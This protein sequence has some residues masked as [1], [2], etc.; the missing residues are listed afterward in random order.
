MN[1][2]INAYA[3]RPNAG[4]EAGVAWRLITGLAAFHEL[5]VITEGEWRDEIERELSLVPNGE[6]IHFYFNPVSE[7]IRRMC[8]NQ[9]DYRFYFYYAKWQKQTLSI[10]KT[11]VKTTHIDIIHQLNMIGFREPGYLYEIKDIPFVWGP[12]GGMNQVPMQYLKEAP[13]VTRLKYYLKNYVSRWQYT[14]YN[15]VQRVMD[16]ADALIAA[17]KASYEV[18]KSQRPDKYVE[19]I[20]E[21]GCNN[22][23]PDFSSKKYD[24]QSFRILWVGRFIPTKLLDLSLEVINRIK[25]LD[26]VEFHIVGKAF[27]EKDTEKY[28]LKASQMGLD[29]I[30]HW[31]GWV[32]HNEVQSLMQNSDVFFFPSVVEGTP[33]VVLEAIANCLPVVC[34]N[35]CGQAEVVN[36]RIGRKIPLRSTDDSIDDFT[37]IFEELYGDRKLLRQL[38]NECLKRREELSWERKIDQVEA[39]YE[40]VIANR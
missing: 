24:E 16:R 4:S 11:I 10:A 5:H 23:N 15:R 17:N 29:N 12:I 21:T 28:M 7:K 33:H 26:R 3:C 9:G 25:G 1:I 18:L 34:F 27:N 14:H 38:S 22:I 32:S 6:R 35:T 40:K 30:C 2:L 19:L 31:H 8:W 36:E 37:Q 39:V 13:I 20:N